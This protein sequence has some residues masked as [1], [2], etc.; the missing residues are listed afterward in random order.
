MEVDD[1]EINSG[2][3]KVAP[4]TNDVPEG[5]RGVKATSLREVSSSQDHRVID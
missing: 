1:A 5:C 3:L 2:G 4:L